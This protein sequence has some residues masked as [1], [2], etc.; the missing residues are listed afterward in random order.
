MRRAEWE[1]WPLGHCDCFGTQDLM[2]FGLHN[3]QTCCNSSG[4]FSVEHG[5]PRA[6]PKLAGCQYRLKP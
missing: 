4:S 1:D 3:E 5:E 2:G 6:S